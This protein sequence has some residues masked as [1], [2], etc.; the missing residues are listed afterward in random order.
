MNV[1]ITFFKILTR[2]KA[3]PPPRYSIIIHSFEPCKDIQQF[4][5][6]MSGPKPHTEKIVKSYIVMSPLVVK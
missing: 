4:N 3:E 6:Y 2:S 5:S 1:H